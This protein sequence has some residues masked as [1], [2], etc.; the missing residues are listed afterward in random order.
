MTARLDKLLSS[1]GYCSR[2]D[3]SKLLRSGIVLVNGQPAKSA[4]QKVEAE[5]VTY[6]GQPL[7]PGPG[8]LIMLHKPAGF[9]CSHSDAGESVFDLLPRR[10]DCRNPLLSCVG[11]LDKDTTGLLLLTDDGELLHKLTSP[12]HHTAKV[13]R[14]ELEKDLQGN[15]GKVFASGELMLEEEDSPL[16]PAEMQV[17]NERTALLT[18]HEGRYHQVKRMFLALDN[19]VV[20]LHRVSVGEYELGDLAEGSWRFAECKSK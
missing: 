6:E 18:L 2:R 19:K 8:M 15:E 3:V 7:D 4:D 14:V 9:I 17:L 10:F 16:L 20:K 1:L 11:R 13:Y 12:K 5:H